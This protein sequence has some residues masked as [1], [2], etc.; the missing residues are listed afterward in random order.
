M[1]TTKVVLD[2]K[3]VADNGVIIEYC[4]DPSAGGPAMLDSSSL[5]RVSF[6]PVYA[7]FKP[8][9]PA[10]TGFSG[11]PVLPLELL[12][13]NFDPAA[14]Q[15][16]MYLRER[17]QEVFSHLN[18]FCVFRALVSA[19]GEVVLGRCLEHL[20]KEAFSGT[21]QETPELSGRSIHELARDPEWS[22]L[23]SVPEA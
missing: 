17:A 8:T 9:R 4:V 14:R 2:P 1:K 11:F 10:G 20:L 13:P 21:S 7:W 23:L 19:R 22:W 3:T 12:V 18:T 15:S 6:T 16:L 5:Q